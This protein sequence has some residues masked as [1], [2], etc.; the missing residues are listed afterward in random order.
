MDIMTRAFS[1]SEAGT[2]AVGAAAGLGMKYAVQYGIARG[3]FSNEAGLGSLAILHGT[4]EDTSPE[5]QGM[6][7]Y[8]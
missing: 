8:V 5:E 4:A 2:S 1:P 6:L 3:V 7:G